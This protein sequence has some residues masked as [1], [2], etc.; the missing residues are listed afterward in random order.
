MKRRLKILAGSSVVALV[1]C[2]AAGGSRTDPQPDHDIRHHGTRLHQATGQPRH[3]H[4]H[5]LGPN[6][7]GTNG[8]ND[9]GTN[10]PNDHGT[11]GPNDHAIDDHATNDH[12]ALGRCNDHD[13]AR[14]QFRVRVGRHVASGCPHLRDLDRVCRR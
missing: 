14:H 1:A 7:H 8:P 4:D 11:N 12:V 6:D 5:D 10:G 2:G 13:G 3:D 9:H